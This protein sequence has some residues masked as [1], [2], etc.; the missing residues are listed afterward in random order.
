[1]KDEL[2]TIV[3]MMIEIIEKCKLDP[4]KYKDDSWNNMNVPGVDNCQ[5]YFNEGRKVS[6]FMCEHLEYAHYSGKII[7]HKTKM[8]DPNGFKTVID[9]LK[10][11]H[12]LVFKGIV[13]RKLNFN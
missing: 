9:S 13:K 2:N 6:A 4:V 3:R 5:V 1:M 8:D 10:K 12:E 7:F 11:A